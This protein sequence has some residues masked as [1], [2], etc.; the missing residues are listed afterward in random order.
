MGINAVRHISNILCFMQTYQEEIDDFK[1]EH[2]LGIHQQVRIDKP[3][4]IVTDLIVVEHLNETYSSKADVH[5]LNL[6]REKLDR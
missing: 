1:R 3:E 6:D 2:G 5:Q 4:T